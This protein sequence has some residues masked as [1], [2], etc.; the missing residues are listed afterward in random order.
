M[1]HDIAQV[2]D[3]QLDI[4]KLVVTRL[5]GEGTLG[6]RELAQLGHDDLSVIGA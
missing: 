3:G 2:R 5:D 6:L 1:V 4:L